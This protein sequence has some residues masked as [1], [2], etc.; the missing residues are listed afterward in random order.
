MGLVPAI[1]PFNP[2][3]HPEMLKD[4]LDDSGSQLG[5]SMQMTPER[6]LP[7]PGWASLPA[8]PPPMAEGV[9]C[10]WDGVWGRMPKPL[11]RG[12]RE[13]EEVPIAGSRRPAELG[14]GHI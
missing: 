12:G 7:G 9:F 14:A 4:P 11:G 2:H 13:V 10:S 5:S 6:T 3:P 8:G 1:T